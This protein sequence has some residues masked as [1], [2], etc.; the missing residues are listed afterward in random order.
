M[1]YRDRLRRRH[2]IA[3]F[4]RT[5]TGTEMRHLLGAICLA[6][7]LTACQPDAQTNN[8]AIATDSAVA[9]REASAPA[10]GASSFTEAQAQDHLISKGYTN[11]TAL[12]K[13]PSGEWVGQASMNGRTVNVTIDYQGNVIA[14]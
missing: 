4:L 14:S 1:K 2:G 6:A 7:A 11:P 5:R 3:D 10:T 9:E 13:S 8:P 12:T